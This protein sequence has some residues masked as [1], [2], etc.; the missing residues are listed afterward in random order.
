[1]AH[2]A[3]E[4]SGCELWVSMES[5]V[6]L[7]GIGFHHFVHPATLADQRGD[8]CA[9]G[10][11]HGGA[12]PGLALFGRGSVTVLGECFSERTWSARDGCVVGDVR[13]GAGPAPSCGRCGR[14]TYPLRPSDKDLLHDA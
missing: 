6:D 14:G 8:L 7:R 4:K 10:R 2:A 5:K 11:F 3:S 13:A 1:M 12:R 9:R